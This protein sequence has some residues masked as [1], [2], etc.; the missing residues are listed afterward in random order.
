MNPGPHPYH[1]CALPTELS[2]RVTSRYCSKV[3]SYLQM[4]Y[5]LLMLH[6]LSCN[7]TLGL[8]NV[9]YCSNLCQAEH[10]YLSYIKDWKKGNKDGSRGINVKALSKHVIRYIFNKYDNKCAKC[11]WSRINPITGNTP[12]EVDHINGNAADNREENLILLCP[13]CHSLTPNHRN[14]NKGYGRAWRREKY[15]KIV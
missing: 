11:S 14:L 5:Y 1:G 12:L 2:R 3:E 7:K 10:Q 9:K 6:C 8:H 15:V 13:N 4:C